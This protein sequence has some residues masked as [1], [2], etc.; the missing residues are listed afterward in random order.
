M[1]MTLM[2]F[3]QKGD[4]IKEEKEN[5]TIKDNA[6]FIKDKDVI[7]I[8]RSA[9]AD[10]HTICDRVSRKHCSLIKKD[11]I[12]FVTDHNST[13]GTFIYRGSTFVVQLISGEFPLQNGDTISLG[14]IIPDEFVFVLSFGGE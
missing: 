3:K 12:W 1:L 11:K 10:I 4:V 6:I 13:G 9:N 5:I 14:G 2:L 8:G 7:T